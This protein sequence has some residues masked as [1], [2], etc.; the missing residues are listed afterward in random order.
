MG[1]GLQIEGGALSR[2]LSSEVSSHVWMVRRSR[3]GVVRGVVCAWARVA[4]PGG[5]SGRLSSEV[6][7]AFGSQIEGGCCPRCCLTCHGWGSQIQGGRGA[8]VV[9]GVAW[10]YGSKNHLLSGAG[11]NNHLLVPLQNHL[12]VW[13]RKEGFLSFRRLK[14]STKG[15]AKLRKKGSIRI[16]VP[17]S[18]CY[19]CKK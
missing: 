15:P 2:M 11:C 7:S 13:R 12:L 18:F 1:E 14:V 16:Y 10:L 9:L 3:E 4:D 17:S 6:S 19:P 5:L 8:G